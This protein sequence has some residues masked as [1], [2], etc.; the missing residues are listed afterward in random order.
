[1]KKSKLIEMITHEV[2]YQI[3]E[4]F[5]S[6]DPGEHYVIFYQFYD[7]IDDHSVHR[8]DVWLGG[9]RI[10]PGQVSSNDQ[11][12]K[13]FRRKARAYSFFD[14][15]EDEFKGVTGLVDYGSKE[16]GDIV[17]M[18]SNEVMARTNPEGS[19]AIAIPAK[20]AKGMKTPTSILSD[21]ND[22]L[23]II[24]RMAGVPVDE[25][26]IVKILK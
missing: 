10:Q 8:E 26:E 20:L 16:F 3:S 7:I 22:Y 15:W 9:G 24:A 25:I 21:N 12:R 14:W 13:G 1:M 19:F 5:P 23:G 17:F 2:N 11:V 18:T 6:T 4:M